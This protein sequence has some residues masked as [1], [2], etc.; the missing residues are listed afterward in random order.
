M[1]NLWLFCSFSALLLT[2]CQETQP[3]PPEP[4]DPFATARV[5]CQGLEG[6]EWMICLRPE[7]APLVLE[8]DSIL[9]Y[10]NATNPP[11][12]KS[13]IDTANQRSAEVFEFCVRRYKSPENCM[14]ERLQAQI[15][16][17][18]LELPDYE[19]QN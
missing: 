3:A 12:R 16:Q 19:T 10:L 1:K 13:I 17:M 15:D 18:L 9:T 5:L 14:D 4:D 7:L 2:A 6:E 8:R 11:H